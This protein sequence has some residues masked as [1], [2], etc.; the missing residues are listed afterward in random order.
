M[1]KEPPSLNP[2]INSIDL[3]RGIALCGLVPINIQDFATQTED[4]FLAPGNS[5]SGLGLGLWWFVATFG[6]MKF[7]S[8]FSILFGASLILATQKIQGR[9]L[10]VAK[11]YLPRLGWL[12]GFGMLHAYLLWDGDILVPYS[13]IGML[14]FFC[15][16]ISAKVAGWIG[17]SIQIAGALLFAGLFFMIYAAGFANELGESWYGG[18][19]FSELGVE[20]G[21]WQ[22]RVLTVLLVH[23]LGIPFLGLPFCGSLMLIGVSLF[24]SGFFEYRWSDKNYRMG[25]G[26]GLLTGIMLSAVG[27]GLSFIDPTYILSIA[28]FLLAIPPLFFAYANAIVLWSR[29]SIFAWLQNGFKSLGR[30]AFSNYIGHTLTYTVIFSI[31]GFQDRLPFEQV[32][33]ICV[34]IWIF[35]MTFSTLWL[36]KFRTGPLEWV[37]RKLAAPRKPAIET[38]S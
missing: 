29:T 19:D 27:F 1:E 32:M 15:R 31:F 5:F 17:W 38:G 25:A 23:F 2:R 8:L 37:W 28:F 24:K 6:M 35:Q 12:W 34:G 18:E 13:I 26:L 14:I 33:L 20:A 16:G 36:K 21:S 7:I 4:W 3:I 30:M 11:N 22:E 9:G 10:P